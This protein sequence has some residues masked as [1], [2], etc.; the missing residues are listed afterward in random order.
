MYCIFSDKFQV[1]GFDLQYVEKFG[2]MFSVYYRSNFRCIAFSVT[3]VCHPFI[4]FFRHDFYWQN[5]LPYSV[6][7][8]NVNIFLNAVA[9]HQK[10]LLVTSCR[11]F[12]ESK[13]YKY[14]VARDL[15]VLKNALSCFGYSIIVLE[16]PSVAKFLQRQANCLKT[17][18][19]RSY[20]KPS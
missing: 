9:I 1:S 4:P 17:I 16:G 15:G 7:V 8:Q 13:Q 6:E 19:A 2:L 3:T 11:G 14:L 5:G 10:C 18:S 20:A 12:L